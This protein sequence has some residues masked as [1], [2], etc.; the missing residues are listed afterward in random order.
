MRNKE[1]G[2]MEKG[3]KVFVG[4]TYVDLVAEREE[5]ALAI[6]ECGCTHRGMELFFASNKDPWTVIKKDIDDSDLYLLIIAGRYGSMTKDDK[7]KDIGFTEKEY[8]YA[9]STDK[10]IFVF[11]HNNPELIQARFVERDKRQIKR[12]KDFVEKVR[13]KHTAAFW[14][15]KARLHISILNSLYK[16]IYGDPETFNLIRTDNNPDSFEKEL[17]V[18]IP[19]LIDELEKRAA[20]YEQIKLLKSLGYEKKKELFNKDVFVKYFLRLLDTKN[21]ESTISEAITLIPQYIYLDEHIRDIIISEAKII[22]SFKQLCEQAEQKNNNKLLIHIIRLLRDMREFGAEYTIP[23]FNIL[24]SN[25]NDT[26]LKDA[27]FNY[28]EIFLNSAYSNKIEIIK[29]QEIKDIVDYILCGLKNENQLFPKNKWIDLLLSS[30]IRESDLKLIHEVF[31]DND[32]ET[33]KFV[34]NGMYM[35]CRAS[36]YIYDIKMQKLFF[37][38]FDEVISWDDDYATSH[39]LR[40]CLLT[41]TDDIYTA[42]EIFEKLNS[43]NDDVFYMFFD[44]IKY[45]EHNYEDCYSLDDTEKERIRNII[46]K[47]NHP[48]GGRLLEFFK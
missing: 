47:R 16:T 18:S 5:A 43:V 32:R 41:R 31:F 22:G 45:E 25:S 17:S 42:D 35:F 8:D 2:S 14:K 4:S 15:N 1:L 36:M 13:N 9:V 12:L 39:I 30:C 40:Y 27:C 6:K 29:P 33:K 34:L 19:A 46:N 44:S 38:I 10:D 37:E 3:Y 48:R 11:L 26:D 28:S 20:G 21:D 7:G 23:I 24:K